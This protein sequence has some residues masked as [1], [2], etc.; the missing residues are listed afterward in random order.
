VFSSPFLPLY[1]ITYFIL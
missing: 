1:P